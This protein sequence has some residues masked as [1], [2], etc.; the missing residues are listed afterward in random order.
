VRFHVTAVALGTLELFLCKMKTTV[1]KRKH[2]FRAIFLS[3]LLCYVELWIE[4]SRG[5]GRGKENFAFRKQCVSE[6]ER[7]SLLSG[8]F[9][10]LWQINVR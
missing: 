8:K 10:R 2:D 7:T 1:S 9:L 4:P 5:D 3:N 6:G